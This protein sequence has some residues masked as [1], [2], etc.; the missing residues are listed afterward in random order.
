MF[1]SLYGKSILIEHIETL[2]VIVCL[3]CAEK[4]MSREKKEKKA[5]ISATSYLLERIR[6][7]QLQVENLKSELENI[8]RVPSV[9]IGIAFLIPGVAALIFS[10]VKESQI[11]A[12]IGLG[13]T[14]WGALF[15]FVRPVRYVKSKLL[16]SASLSSYLTIDRIIKDLKFKGKSYYI[17]P[18]PE[19]VYLP[20]HLKGLKEMVVFIS[21]NKH[22][23]M[24][25]IEEIAKS[26]FLLKN[27]NGICIPPPGLGL[28]IQF[29][30][31]LGRDLS[32]VDLETVLEVL[33]QLV[34][35][36]IPLAKQLEIEKEDGIIHLRI[37]N[38][39]YKNM[40]NLEGPKS[41]HILGCPIVSAI[42]C[43]IAKSTGKVVTIKEDKISPDEQLIE[44]WYSLVAGD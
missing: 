35:E 34:T 18:Y 6:E 31:T 4:Y 27:P 13:L 25:S 40:Y 10:V 39:I 15:L 42:A 37:L 14:F 36:G 29:E 2:K 3:F 32:K 9:K 30:R 43:A 8:E 20:E 21:A 38:S 16:H 26:K 44:V 22:P 17:P 19:D 12:F 41:V 5:E 23:D 28:L 24:P 33:P 1:P 11:L 7:L